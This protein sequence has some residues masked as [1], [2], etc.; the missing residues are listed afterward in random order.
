RCGRC[1]TATGATTGF[2]HDTT[3]LKQCCGTILNYK[4]TIRSIRHSN[5]KIYKKPP[6]KAVFF[7]YFFWFLHTYA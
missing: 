4:A 7:Q 2:A 6:F 1:I 3:P 5:S